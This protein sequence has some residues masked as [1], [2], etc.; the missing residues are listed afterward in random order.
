MRTIACAKGHHGDCKGQVTTGGR[1]QDTKMSAPCDC[2]C[3]SKRR[4]TEEGIENLRRRGASE[5][6]IRMVER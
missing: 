3:H 5:A 2:E 4:V 6:F 1:P